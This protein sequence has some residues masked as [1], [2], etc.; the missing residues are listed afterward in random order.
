MCGVTRQIRYHASLNIKN[1]TNSKTPQTGIKEP[2]D[3]SYHSWNQV[4]CLTYITKRYKFSYE[5]QP[6]KKLLQKP[7]KY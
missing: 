6:F 7:K 1:N 4:C 5:T 2:S 3:Q